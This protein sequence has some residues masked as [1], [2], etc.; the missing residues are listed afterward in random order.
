M[1][2][3]KIYWGQILIVFAIVLAAV[4][5]AT[6]WTAWRLAYQPQLGLP[7]FWLLLAR[8]S[9]ARLLWWWFTFDAYAPTSSSRAP[10]SPPRVVSSPW[11][12]PSACRCGARA[13]RRPPRPTARRVGR[14]P[15]EIRTCRPARARWRGAGPVPAHLS[16]PRRSRAR[17]VF[18]ADQIGQGRGS[19]DPVA[20][21]LA[22]RRDRP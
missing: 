2:A 9:A 19:G 5:G 14:N 12:S 11:P 13:R 3:T 21:D 10:I 22:G 20:L 6:Q 17:A 18:C 4:W 1:S 7:W 8:L 15:S 16:A